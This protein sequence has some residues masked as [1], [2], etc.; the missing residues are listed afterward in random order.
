MFACTFYTCKQ[1]T[2]SM[3]GSFGIRSADIC[4]FIA[5]ILNLCAK[6][7][8]SCC[9]CVSDCVWYAFEFYFDIFGGASFA[10]FSLSA[11]H[12]IW[13][14]TEFKY[15][16]ARKQKKIRKKDVGRNSAT[17]MQIRFIFSSKWKQVFS[18]FTKQTHYP[19]TCHSVYYKRQFVGACARNLIF[20]SSFF[21]HFGRLSNI[22]AASVQCTSRM[23]PKMC[24]R[25]PLMMN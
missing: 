12:S 19:H 4:N 7:V 1:H 25:R 21:F 18:A 6:Y 5:C 13:R 20:G 24:V 3:Y 11:F 14:D 17:H 22:K 2:V 23:C 16:F 10:F 9:E 15:L 8:L